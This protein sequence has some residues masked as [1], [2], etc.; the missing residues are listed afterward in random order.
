MLRIP[1]RQHSFRPYAALGALIAERLRRLRAIKVNL[2]ASTNVD[3]SEPWPTIVRFHPVRTRL[4]ETTVTVGLNLMI[5]LAFLIPTTLTIR[6]DF[7]VNRVIFHIGILSISPGCLIKRIV[8][9]LIINIIIFVSLII[10]CH[11]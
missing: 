8:S 6:L 7:M 1:M 3:C 4:M 9:P 11:I 5:N 10:S 2:M